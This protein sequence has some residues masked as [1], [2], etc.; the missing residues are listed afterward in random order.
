MGDYADDAFDRELSE[1][2]YEDFP[3]TPV[4]RVKEGNA[5]SK[6]NCDGRYVTRTNKKTG[7]KFLGCSRFPKCRNTL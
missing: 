2:M 5:C 4:I 1:W 7:E 3:E 6:V